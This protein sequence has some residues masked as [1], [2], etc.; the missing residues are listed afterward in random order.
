MSDLKAPD[1]DS[2][3]SRI[4]NTRVAQ[5]DRGERVGVCIVFN[6]EHTEE[7]VRVILGAMGIEPGVQ[8]ERVE[9]RTFD[10][11]QGGPEFLLT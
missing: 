1:E 11:A 2:V 10:C 3:F 5:T 8:C 9:I 4:M 6:K 7:E